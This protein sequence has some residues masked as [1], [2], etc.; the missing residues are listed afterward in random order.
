MPIKTVEREIGGTRYRI[1][2]L[3]SLE[4]ADILLTIGRVAG[5]GW[6]KKAI[7]AVLRELSRDDL[8][9]MRAAFERTTTLLHVD[10]AKTTPGVNARW[11]PLATF[12]QDDH[13]AGKYL[14]LVEW[15][16]AHVELNYRDFFVGLA[17]LFE[18]LAKAT[19]SSRST[20]PSPSTG[21]SGESLQA[22]GLP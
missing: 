1:S 2:S 15:I 19:V 4:G 17:G 14:E 10:E 13:F 8:R 16:V 12:G 18:R 5:T 7:G 20:S 3:G 6:D 21:T 9:V 11:L 22:N